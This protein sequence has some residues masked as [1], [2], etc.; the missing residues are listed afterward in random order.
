[1]P[2][3]PATP[4]AKLQRTP[5]SAPGGSKVSEEKILVTVRLRPL[6]RREQVMYDLIAWD[7]LDEHT[8]VFKE[9]ES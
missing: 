8:I 5:C 9:S 4:S 1:M 2:G 6:N 7:C 3:T